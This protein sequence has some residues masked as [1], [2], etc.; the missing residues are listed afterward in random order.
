MLTLEQALQNVDNVCAMIK[1]SRE[2]HLALIESM[3]IIK[4]ALAKGGSPDKPQ[5]VT[6][7]SEMKEAK[8]P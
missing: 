1:A 8:E 2:E 6:K 7:A 5:I 3:K 4:A